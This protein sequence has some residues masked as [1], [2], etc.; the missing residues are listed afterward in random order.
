[1]VGS[2]LCH[3]CLVLQPFVVK[4]AC[5]IIGSIWRGQ[6]LVIDPE[7]ELWA[8]RVSLMVLKYISLQDRTCHPTP[9]YRRRRASEGSR[10]TEEK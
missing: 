9:D 3:K 6:Q 5:F 10:S 1:M 4:V 2:Q 7:N 8:E